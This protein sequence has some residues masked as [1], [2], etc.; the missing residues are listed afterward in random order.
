LE[1]KE[2]DFGEKIFRNVP[3]RLYEDVEPFDELDL[4]EASEDYFYDECEGKFTIEQD[5]LDHTDILQVDTS[6]FDFG[7]FEASFDMG[8]FGDGADS[9][10]GGQGGG[11]S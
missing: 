7:D 11:Q 2:N 6:S 4:D 10:A 8:D 9:D 3:F 1:K 5:Q